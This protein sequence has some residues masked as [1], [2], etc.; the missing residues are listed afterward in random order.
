MTIAPLRKSAQE[1]EI[2]HLLAEEFACDPAFGSR[3]L[4]AC[5]LDVAE[6]AVAATVA[7]PS[8]NGDGFGDLLVEGVSSS[9]H[10]IALLIE[11]KVTAAPAVRQAERYR[12]FAAALLERGYDQVWTILV[13]PASYC[14]E[15]NLYDACISLETIAT[16][17]D[18]PDPLRRAY[19]GGIIERAISK[20]ASSGVR[21]PD[22]AMHRLK[23]DYLKFAAEWSARTDSTFIFPALR[24][25]YYDADSWV[26]PITSPSL[27]TGAK[28][29]H[30]LWTSSKDVR[31]FVDLIVSPISEGDGQR[32]KHHAP[33]N[34]T[35]SSYSNGKG[36]QIS[37]P[38]PEL[39]Q[40]PGFDE[41]IAL[42]A[43]NKMAILTDW[44]A[45]LKKG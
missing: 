40:R 16:I 39:R 7:E 14:G 34:A 25:S 5:G 29:R 22:A 13:A 42:E 26:E 19:R 18:S 6:I 35:V 33:G 45:A 41:V 17:I 23:A 8:L 36:I 2:D 43:L 28:I 24:Q 44:Y 20:K 12:N 27:P 15:R 21:I 1:V 31:G 3:F 9:G 11:D 37:L 30:R 4:A 32:L 10:K 38:V